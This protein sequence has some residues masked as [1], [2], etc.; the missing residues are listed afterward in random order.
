[1]IKNFIK[2]NLFIIILNLIFFYLGVLCTEIYLY[3]NKNTKIIKTELISP[4]ENILKI[5]KTSPLFIEA[6]FKGD[7]LKIL[8]NNNHQETLILENEKKIRL[9]TQ[10]LFYN[11]KDLVPKDTKYFASKKGKNVY[12]ITDNQK[13]NQLNFNNLIFFKSLEEAKKQGF[14]P[15]LP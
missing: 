2:K 13:F 6:S 15:K 11:L 8:T 3:Q 7:N 14:T 12:D 10:S 5:T 4:K 9:D 1:M